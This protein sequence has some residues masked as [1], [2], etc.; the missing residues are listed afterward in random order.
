MRAENQQPVSQPFHGA[1]AFLLH[2]GRIAVILRD[3]RPDIAWPNHWDMPGGGREAEEAP[4][5]CLRRETREEL[6]ID[7]HET[8][9]IWH[10]TYE[11]AAGRS[12]WF[13]VTIDDMRAAGITLG[14]EGQRWQWMRYGDYLDHPRAIAHFADRL[15]DFM[16]AQP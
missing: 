13:A 6:G 4:F 3:D 14:D 10:Q 7:I 16:A 15:R 2:R 12:H 9:V 8:D 11:S 5:A 1:K